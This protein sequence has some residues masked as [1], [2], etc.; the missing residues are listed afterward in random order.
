MEAAKPDTHVNYPPLARD[1]PAGR[2]GFPPQHLLLCDTVPVIRETARE[3][4]SG[5]CNSWGFIKTKAG[6]LLSQAKF[7]ETWNDECHANGFLSL[8][9]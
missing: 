3:K 7:P 2:G 8:A 1:C 5:I 6:R 4:T 9:Q